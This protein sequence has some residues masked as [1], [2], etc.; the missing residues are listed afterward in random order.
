[1]SHGVFQTRGCLSSASEPFLD[2]GA[3]ELVYNLAFI[4]TRCLP[5]SGIFGRHLS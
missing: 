2:F 5:P 4:G 1:M 3:D